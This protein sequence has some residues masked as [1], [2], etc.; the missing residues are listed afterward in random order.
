[1]HRIVWSRRAQSDLAGI[2]DYVSQFAPL[3][4]QRLAMRLIGAAESL[5]EHPLRGR[6]IGGD[7]RAIVAIP[8]YHIR[9]R[10]IGETVEIITIRHGAREPE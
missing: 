3:A 4:A 8:P 1:L 5:S 9:Y 7:R 10:V 6:S 2:R